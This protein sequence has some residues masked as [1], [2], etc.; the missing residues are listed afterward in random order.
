MKELFLFFV[1]CSEVV[2]TMEKKLNNCD[3]TLRVKICR[4]EFK[5]L[6]V[7]STHSYNY[8]TSTKTQ[9]STLL[10]TKTYTTAVMVVYCSGYII[11]L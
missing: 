10:Y 2:A 8:F 6:V 9:K 5:V 7:H 3:H 4:S 1:H 11:L